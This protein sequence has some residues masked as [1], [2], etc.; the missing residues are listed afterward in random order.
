MRLLSSLAVSAF[1]AFVFVLVPACSSSD[2]QDPGDPTAQDDSEVRSKKKKTCGSAGGVCVGLAPGSCPSDN[3][4][5]ATKVSCGGGLG[6][7]CCLPSVVPPPPEPS[8]PTLSPPAPG[9]CPN[10]TV[11]PRTN[12]NGCV[13]G[14]DCVPSNLNAC[15]S[16][17][18]A[19]VGIAPSSCPDGRWGE[20]T[21]FSCGG[22]IGAGCCLPSCPTLSPPAP[23]FCP[24]GKTV[25]RIDVTGCVTGYDCVK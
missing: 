11:V 15:E 9:F 16:V 18:G 4:A 8:C 10:G 20:P 13:T 25:P 24:G 19:C 17:G 12:A 2:D 6:T 22:G 7:G 1:A 5:D 23:G 3:W 21:K 14:Y